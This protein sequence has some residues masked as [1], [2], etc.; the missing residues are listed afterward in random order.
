M[1]GDTSVQRRN[2]FAGGVLRQQRVA[3]VGFDLLRGDAD[4]L[5]EALFDEAQ[6]LDAVAQ[7]GFDALRG[8]A[9][10]GQKC[11]PSRIR[12]AVLANA[13]GQFLANL[14][15]PGIDLGL[16]RLNGLRVLLAN[17]LLDQRAADQLVQRALPGE[18]A[19]SAAAGVEHRSRISSSTS[20]ARMAW[21]L[22]T[23]TTRSSTTGLAAASERAWARDPGSRASAST[24][25]T[26]ASQAR[27]EFVEPDWAAG[28]ASEG[29]PQA[30]EEVE[31]AAF[32]HVRVRARVE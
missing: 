22:T 19:E 26:N 32:A 8:Q 27:A 29:L 12:G 6:N 16:R 5:A 7:I 13:G 11:L 3:I 10:R 23:A 15:E 25:N 1:R 2:R 17:L 18:I 9:V 14:H 4:S 31:V 30:E 28:C 21:L 24:G 20:L